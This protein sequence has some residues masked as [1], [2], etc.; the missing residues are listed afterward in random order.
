MKLAFL[1]MATSLEIQNENDPM[2]LRMVAEQLPEQSSGGIPV[3]PLGNVRLGIC[4]FRF[5]GVV[6]KMGS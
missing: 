6:E 5:I 1:V 3:Q 4:S 2:P